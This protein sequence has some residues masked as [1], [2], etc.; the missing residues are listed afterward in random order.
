MT[1]GVWESRPSCGGKQ[2]LA[3][4]AQ[5]VSESEEDSPQQHKSTARG[6][7]GTQLC[8][9]TTFRGVEAL[10]ARALSLERRAID[11]C[12]PAMDDG[13]DGD[14][15]DARPR[16]A[17]A[18]PPSASARLQT[19][20]HR[21]VVVNLAAHCEDIAA[22]KASRRGPSHDDPLRAR[23]PPLP[24]GDPSSDNRDLDDAE[25]DPAPPSDAF[26]FARRGVTPLRA[27]PIRHHLLQ[28]H[29]TTSVDAL[30]QV[31]PRRLLEYSP[32]LLHTVGWFPWPGSYDL[33]V[34]VFANWA[35]HAQ[36]ALLLSWTALL[37]LTG[38][39]VPLG[40]QR[41]FAAIF[42][43]TYLGSLASMGVIITLVLG[44]F[45]SLL[46]QRWWD[47]RSGYAL[48]HSSLLEAAVSFT[49]ASETSRD[50]TRH[51]RGGAD[52]GADEGADAIAEDR[53][54]AERAHREFLRLLNLA[55][56]LFL[57]Q[58]G[59]K[60]HVVAAAR[61]LQRGG[62]FLA[63]AFGR[64]V[65]VGA[66]LRRRRRRQRTNPPSLDEDDHEDLDDASGAP[67]SMPPPPTPDDSLRGGRSFADART[68]RRGPRGET[69]P[70]TRPR[71]GSGS[72][73]ESS[74]APVFLD[75]DILGKHVTHLGVDDC[76]A[77]GLVTPDEWDRLTRAQSV[78][79]PRF[80]VALCWAGELLGDSHAAGW[81]D[82]A[83]HASVRGRLN[84]AA[85]AAGR[86]LTYLAS[87]LPYTY[88]HLVSLVVHVYLFT[89]ATWFGF[90]MCSG[91]NKLELGVVE[92]GAADASEGFDVAEKGTS[93]ASDALTLSFGYVFV[94]FSN[95][96][97]QGLLNMHALLDNPFGHHPAK[98]P[99]RSFVA[100]LIG[101]TNALAAGA[102]RPPASSPFR[103]LFREER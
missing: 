6:S 15:G 59:E 21:A 11:V 60:E 30:W 18:S 9:A 68:P 95:V 98:F 73:F 25:D 71:G 78:G 50:P 100:Q 77:M 63:R 26:A 31:Q 28:A 89:L 41:H 29:V 13:C 94:A 8:F 76:V 93:L 40:H 39:G 36:T 65:L 24:W 27:P 101:T 20:P 74:S 34:T 82:A 64:R 97:F 86:V 49:Q 57:S 3:Y 16:P 79:M 37:H 62:G 48:L 67:T 2:V 7:W 47:M 75:N 44:L 10:S 66:S 103:A 52:E 35:L 32:Q 53:S 70:D 102:H 14:G 72:R 87:Q 23:S 19:Q 81:I 69:R 84:A 4:G 22:A 33:G 54:R 80:V 90:V 5:P 42:G 56:V 43:T 61:A 51:P 12:T 45:V 91:L 92:R 88:V 17:N 46:V 55:H 83:T 96:L 99:L 38:L 58:A 85:S 1:R